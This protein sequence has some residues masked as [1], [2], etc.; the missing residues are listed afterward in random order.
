MA[1]ASNDNRREEAEHIESER[2]TA[3]VLQLRGMF[4]RLSVADHPPQRI[5]RSPHGVG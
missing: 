3:L 2:I 5:E 4:A 1:L